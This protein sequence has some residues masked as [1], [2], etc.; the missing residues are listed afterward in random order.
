VIT[1]MEGIG[2]NGLERLRGAHSQATTGA[3]HRS[4][5]VAGGYCVLAAVKERR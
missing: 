5:S 1:E 4:N 2:I 3:D